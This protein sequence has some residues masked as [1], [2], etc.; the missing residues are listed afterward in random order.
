M[1]NVLRFAV[2]V[3][4]AGAI[5]KFKALGTEAK[6]AG[7][8][9]SSGF[10]SA[11]GALSKVE[12]GLGGVGT[13][14]G[15]AKSQITGLL[16]SVGMLAGAGG[17]LSLGGA[18]EQGISKASDMALAVEKVTGATN[19]SAHAAS[20][21]VAVFG[22][23]GLSGDQ[24]AT[25]LGRLEKNAFTAAN[26]QKLATKFQSEYGLSL[27]DSSGK[28]KDATALL[29]TLSD[30]Y[31]KNGD[32]AQTDAAMAKLLGKT[33]I[34]LIPVLKQGSQGLADQAK[35]ADAMGT[36]LSS[37]LDVKSVNAFIAAQRDAGEAVSGLETQL[38]LL[39]MPDLTAGL[40][41]FVG[42]VMTNKAQIKTFFTDALHAGE[43]FTGF[44]TN[45]VVPSLETIGGAAVKVWNM[46][47]G[48]VK[49][50]LVKGFLADKAIKWTFGIDVAGLVGSSLKGVIGG[51]I[52]NLFKNATTASMSVQ[53][54]VVNVGGAGVPGGSPVNTA[55]NTVENA[56]GPAAVMTG[57]SGLIAG[58]ITVAVPLV[59][60]AFALKQA[61]D[62]NNQS[63]AVADQTAEFVKTATRAQ[64]I[65]AQQANADA[66][67]QLIGAS[68]YN[69][70]AASAEAGLTRTA[71]ELAA[72][73]NRIDNSSSGG[74]GGYVGQDQYQPVVKAVVDEASAGVMARAIAN[75][76]HPTVTGIAATEAKDA[77]TQ[78]ALI[79]TAFKNYRAGEHTDLAAI[80]HAIDIKQF[81]A[82]GILGSSSLTGN[83]PKVPAKTP[84]GLNHAAGFLGTV[85]GETQMTMGEAGNETVAIL[86]NPR[87]G[88][89]AGAGGALTVNVNLA[90]ATGIITPGAARQ[91]MAELGP[92]MM[93]WFQRQGLMPRLGTPLRG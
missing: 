10:M 77:K 27:V 11:G 37:A 75:G 46:V 51:A 72:A 12:K 57:L 25:M 66:A 29:G 67:K 70:L 85:S 61:S 91:I 19:L 33:W 54:G 71:Q 5:V 3:D 82:T 18:L 59:V 31:I 26:T 21:A 84:P 7:S 89:A 80:Q 36:T 6:S 40:K 23:Y 15:H 76:L 43:E 52:S 14:L 69:P 73:L 83:T 35:E 2:T 1:A 56:A 28:V 78:A 4:D 34:D 64:I 32:N 8:G 62:V 79:S 87:A 42:F 44:I 55:E 92:L 39:V 45:T 22:K 17:L 49:D 50:L 38:G 63:N 74:T 86:R 20:Q 41:G 16:G 53:A 13:A 47:P 81:V 24:T 93:M 88:H 58:A 65:A 48:P 60:G 30:Y 90:S 9:I 68:G